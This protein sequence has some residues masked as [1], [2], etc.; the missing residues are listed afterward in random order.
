M[1]LTSKIND[2]VGRLKSIDGKDLSYERR[3]ADEKVSFPSVY[4]TRP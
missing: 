3:K 1:E 4:L 2:M